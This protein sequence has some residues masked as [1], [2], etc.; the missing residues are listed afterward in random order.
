[1][2]LITLLLCPLTLFMVVIASGFVFRIGIL[3]AAGFIGNR[4]TG[5]INRIL[6]VKINHPTIPQIDTRN[7]IVRTG[8]QKRIIKP[9]FERTRL[10]IAVPVS[11]AY[12]CLPTGTEPQMPLSNDGGVIARFLEQVSECEAYPLEWPVVQPEVRV[13]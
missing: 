5:D 4:L 8:N 12:V 13:R 11:I 7:A 2:P 6:R 1:M 3:R 9:D 10:H